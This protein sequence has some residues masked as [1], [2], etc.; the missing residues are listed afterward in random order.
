MHVPMDVYRPA[1]S[2]KG[3]I[4]IVGG[5]PDEGFDKFVGCK[6]KD[7]PSNVAWARRIADAGMTA[8]TYVN[9]DPV[10][11]LHTVLQNLEPPIGIWASSGNAPLAL[12]LL[13]P[14]AP[15]RVACAALLYPF[16]LD[17]DGSTHVADA[18]STYHFVNPGGSIDDLRTDVPLFIARAGGD[19]F[20][21]LNETLDRFVLHAL[22]R[23]LPITVV[24]HPTGPHAFDIHDDSG[25]TRAIIAQVLAFLRSHL[26]PC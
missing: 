2:S 26:S 4:V 9:R 7:L 24:N 20:P 16:T 10:A 21:G 22:Q 18:S 5:Y 8:V 12:S 23:N 17:F 19:T 3:T 6:F 1:D 15:V 25:T 14:D 11:D 13:R